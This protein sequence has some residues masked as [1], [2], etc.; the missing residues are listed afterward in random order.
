MDL[1]E[2]QRSLL[3]E[4]LQ[5]EA[6]T[7]SRSAFRGAPDNLRAETF[8]GA[9]R[10][11]FRG[12]RR[13]ERGID[14]HEL[15]K[16]EAFAT[17]EPSCDDHFE[18]NRP[19][20][21]S[22]YGIS[23]QYIILDSFSKLRSSAVERGEFRW[24]FMVQGVTGDEVIG[25]KDK[26]DTVIE[27]QMGGFC[28]PNIPEVEYKLQATSEI[29]STNFLVLQHNNNNTAAAGAPTLVPNAA[30][31]GQYPE[32]SLTTGS[33]T[34]SPWINNPY[35]QLPFCN[36]MTIQLREAGLQSYSDRNGARHHYEFNV[37]YLNFV[38]ANP[39]HLQASPLNGS[40]W[41]TYT[42]TEPLK[43]VHGLTLVF[44]NPDNPIEFQ[45][46]CLY[47]IEVVIDL[48]D[49]LMVNAPGH[50][51]NAGDRIHIEAYVSGNSELDAYI[52]RPQGHV[53]N[54]NPGTLLAPI[55]P[56]NPGVL[57][58]SPNFYLDPNVNVSALTTPE[59]DPG[60]SVRATVYIAKRR[61]RIP[62]RVRSVVPRLTNYI[63]P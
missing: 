24:N 58:S 62:I 26:L 23:D 60:L 51:L 37:G 56:L 50:N 20:P 3:A 11:A 40:R 6:S 22:V 25:V 54:S 63:A 5:E 8:R 33:T 34:V 43:D 53:V 4:D 36:R 42:F 16:R 35:S 47:D 27:I 44:R 32:M 15:L 28:M 46:D 55:T 29:G 57:I 39:T 9:P 48:N 45:P 7:R 59:I 2:I 17:R 10:E 18:K 12:T 31:Y 30:P 19:C 21:T 1:H 38:G 41:D 13:A 14:I 61:L 49:N 52:N